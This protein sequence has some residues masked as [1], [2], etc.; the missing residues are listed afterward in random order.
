MGLPEAD[1]QMWDEDRKKPDMAE[2]WQI[3]SLFYVAREVI[4]E[5]NSENVSACVLLCGFST[6]IRG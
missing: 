1:L 4:N 2:F 6:F 3:I 5:I